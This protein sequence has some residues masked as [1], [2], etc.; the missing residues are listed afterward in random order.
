[1]HCITDYLLWLC[2][3]VCVTWTKQIG[4]ASLHGLLYPYIGVIDCLSLCLET[5]A[6]V[7]VDVS[8]DVCVVHTNI[9]DVANR[10]NV[11][12]FTQYTLNRACIPSTPT[13]ALST[14]SAAQMTSQ[15]SSTGR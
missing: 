15:S 11:S 14:A 8:S 7:A 5:Y 9:N 2:R 10:F 4:V 3:T 12:G 6:C 1:M 13:S